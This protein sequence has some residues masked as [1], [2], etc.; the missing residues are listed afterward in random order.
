MNKFLSILVILVSWLGARAQYS[1]LTYY[2]EQTSIFVIIPVSQLIVSE[3]SSLA[4]YQ[5]SLNLLDAKKKTA[6][7]KIHNLR[8]KPDEVPWGASPYYEIR[9]NFTSGN[10]RLVIQL[11]N[12][13]LGD[14]Q[15]ASYNLSL[16]EGK[17]GKNI[18]LIVMKLN[19]LNLIPSGYENINTNPEECY[20]IWTR[21]A[22]TDSVVLKAAVNDS[23]TSMNLTSET[24]FRYD[25]KPILRKGVI[26]WLELQY[27]QKNILENRD[28]LFYN[29]TDNY[30]S[31]Y[32]T[33]DQLQQIKYIASQNEWRIIKKLADKNETEAISYFWK[34][35]SSSPD[36]KIN[37]FKEVFTARVI[38]AD[39][40]YTIHKKLPGWKSDRGRIFII[41]GPP[42]DISEEVFPIGKRPYIIWRYFDDNSTYIFVDKSGFGNYTL[43][44]EDSDF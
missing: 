24:S 39:E 4:D 36:G 10:Y 37:D 12:R 42:D 18:N 11:R 19:G 43:E 5:I 35:H 6:Y 1:V 40:L 30:Q 7:Q 31:R 32:S 3:E 41:K 33:K 25:L 44:A 2:G 27:Y 34:K 21:P 28:W 26:T 9:G 22:E 14:K 29:L 16:G 13:L 8:F 20:L 17:K 38:K 23:T 15:E